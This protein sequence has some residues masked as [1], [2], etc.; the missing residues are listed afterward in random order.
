MHAASLWKNPLCDSRLCRYSPLISK[1]LQDHMLY[2]AWFQVVSQLVQSLLA[3][4]QVMWRITWSIL[5][6][7][8]N[9][10]TSHVINPDARCPMPAFP[11]WN[12]NTIT[13]LGYL[14]N[15]DVGMTSYLGI[16]PV[17][18][19]QNS[20]NWKTWWPD[21]DSSGHI[22]SWGEKGKLY[23]PWTHCINHGGEN[24]PFHHGH[25]VGSVSNSWGSNIPQCCDPSYHT[26]HIS[27]HCL[28]PRHVWRDRG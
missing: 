1:R 18:K 23:S 21:R 9:H 15:Q 17:W 7:R 6:L 14:P 28:C 22:Q 3:L 8:T 5:T 26:N 11:L 19:L 13:G 27:C 16:T 2:L 10:M 25:I 20:N 12:T 4:R 24:S